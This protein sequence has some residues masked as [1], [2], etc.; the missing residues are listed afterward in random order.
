MTVNQYDS[1]A[2]FQEYAKVKRSRKGLSGTGEWHQLR[3]MFP[4]LAGKSVL[5][6]GCGYGW[7]YK[8]AVEQGTFEVLGIDASWQMLEEAKKT[9]RRSED[10]V[11]AL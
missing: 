10:H 7:H 5:D 11:P 3:Q 2:F 6:L 9:K 8:Y 1:V 4:P